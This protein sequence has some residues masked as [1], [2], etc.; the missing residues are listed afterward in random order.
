MKAY[1]DAQ[2][3]EELAEIEARLARFLATGELPQRL[4]E[5]VAPQADYDDGSELGFLYDA[6]PND[7][8]SGK[9]TFA[10]AQQLIEAVEGID[11]DLGRAVREKLRHR[12]KR[13]AAS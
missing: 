8:F 10:D 2:H 3:S 12:R 11:P 13:R 7:F 1:I 6:L 9:I 5:S 4:E